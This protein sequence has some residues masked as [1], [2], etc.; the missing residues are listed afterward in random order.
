MGSTAGG[1]SWAIFGSVEPVIPL[2]NTR[3]RG[4]NWSN[5]R[6]ADLSRSSK[7]VFAPPQISVREAASNLLPKAGSL[8]NKTVQ[9]RGIVPGEPFGW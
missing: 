9:F 5:A 2:P 8:L 6:R 4:S 1:E 3:S 7:H